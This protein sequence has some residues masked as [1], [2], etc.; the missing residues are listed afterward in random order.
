MLDS[1]RAAVQKAGG[2]NVRIVVS[3]S[4]WPSAGGFDASPENAGTYYK[5]LIDHVKRNSIETYL[6]AMYDE[7]KKSGDEIERHFGLFHPGQSSKYQI[8]LN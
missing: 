7:N 4:G 3:E 5:K 6:F 1:M 2:Q 8:A